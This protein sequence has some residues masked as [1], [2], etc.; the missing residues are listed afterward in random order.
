MNKAGRGIPFNF[1]LAY[2]SSVWVPGTAW[3]PSPTWGWSGLSAAGQ[4]EISYTMS[5]YNGR[6]EDDNQ[7]KYKYQQWTY[8]NVQY[9]DPKGVS[10]A[11]GGLFTYTNGSGPD[12]GSGLC[13][14]N[15]ANPVGPTILPSTDGSGLSASALA[16]QAAMRIS[17][18]DASGK[19]ISAPIV[20]N[21]QSQQ[22]TYSLVDL[23]GNEITLTNGQYTDTTGAVALSV[24]GAS[25]SNT[26]LAYTTTAG[27][28][29]NYT[30]S[31]KAYTVK[32]AF[33]C[34]YHT[35]YGPT[36][37]YLVD[38]VTLTDNSFYQFSYEA[39][40]GA[41]GDV[42][43]R[44]AS[45][46]LPTGGAVAYAYT[47]A[48]N[49]INCSDGSALGLTRTTVATG[50]SPASTWTYARTL[51]GSTTSHTEVVD[52]LVNHLAYDFMLAQSRIGNINFTNAMYYETARKVYQGAESGTPVISRT[53]CYDSLQPPCNTVIYTAITA[54][55][56]YEVLDGLQEHGTTT[57][58]GNSG[59]ITEVDLYDFGG[60][61]TRGPVL[62][63]QTWTYPT[64]G[65]TGLLSNTQ[66][67]DAAGDVLSSTSYVYDGGTLTP[68]TG[69]PQH[70][71]VTGQRGN[72]TSIQQ[73]SAGHTETTNL[74][75]ED[76]GQA[77]TSTDPAT[78]KTTLTYD[79]ATHVNLIG[80]SQKV[81]TLTLGSTYAYYGNTGLLQTSTD[82]NSQ[83]T[84]LTYDT[85]LRN[86]GV[87]YPDGG[88]GTATYSI[89][90]NNSSVTQTVLHASGTPITSVTTVD[91]YGRPQ[92]VTVT[93]SPA[94]DLV[95]AVYDANGNTYS[96]S[97]PYRTT[98]D[99]TYGVTTYTHDVLG[100]LTKT[101]APDTSPSTAT[102]LGNT[103]LYADAANHQREILVDGMGRISQ[104]LEPNGTSNTP[105]MATNYSYLQ[106][107]NSSTGTTQAII[108]QT[109]GSATQS[110]WRTRT[111]TSDALGR[112]VSSA[113]PESG[114]TTYTY[115][116]FGNAYCAGNLM[117]PC[118]RTD[119][120]SVV[121]HYT[122]D[123]LNRP[124]GMT[125]TGITPVTPAIAYSYD[126]TA[127]NGL[128]I[129]NG[130]GR[131]TGMTDASGTSAWSFD[132]LGRVAAARKTLNSVTK[133]ANFTYNLDGTVKTLQDFGGTTL[134][135]TY[136]PVGLQSG[137]SDQ[138]G[139]TYAASGA[140]NAAGQLTSLTHQLTSGSAILQRALGYNSLLEPST[141]KATSGG[142]NIQNLTLGYGTPGQ[143]NGNIAGIVNGMDTTHGRDQTYAYD[144]LNR[145]SQGGDTSHW[146]EQYGYDAWGNMLSK[147][148]VRGSGT[149]F[150]V[151]ANGNN[152]LSN[153][154][155]DAAGQVTLDQ[156]GNH[157]TYD[158]EGRIL[159]GGAGTYTYDGDGNRVVKTSGGTTTLYWPSSVSGVVDESNA[160]ATAFGRQIFVAGVRVWSEDTAGSGRFLFQDH[161]GS[162]RVTAVSTGAAKDDYDYRS[163]GDIVTNY[164]AAP[165]DNHYVFTG[166][167]NDS[168]DTGTD[169]AQF[170]SLSLTMARFNRPD[171]YMGSYDFSNPQSSNRYG[172]VLNNPLIMIDPLGLGTTCVTDSWLTT[173]TVYNFNDGTGDSYGLDD[174]ETTDTG[175]G[176]C[177]D[178]GFDNSTIVYNNVDALE[179]GAGAPNNY[180]Q[181]LPNCWA[182]GGKAVL[183]AVGDTLGPVTDVPGLIKAG[184]DEATNVGIRNAVYNAT[185]Y[186]LTAINTKGGVG[187]LSPW[188]SSTYRAIVADTATLADIATGASLLY[189][190]YN[191]V[192]Q[193]VNE[194]KNPTPCR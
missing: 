51:T 128:T 164:G 18:T 37:N 52:G 43:G 88:A 62:E 108:Q 136:T 104:V 182:V 173:Q 123:A 67:L 48:N 121:A 20:S 139:N 156:L 16:L 94:N 80:V 63:T 169:F 180:E 114:T 113:V 3:T 5:L 166:Y 59:L 162:T 1:D 82:P 92:R 89:A 84:T 97:N 23:N 38:K 127:Y 192:K 190:D 150:S 187:L 142:A 151:T 152:Q 135:Y 73:T 131:R 61:S 12:D 105:T 140:Y 50:N 137:V 78:N 7:Q 100:R 75:Y 193:I 174:V 70:L 186:S 31:Y 144:T 32:T 112:L 120:R 147:T 55:D 11:F 141:I 98:G 179:G 9:L 40:P 17:L 54:V 157:F 176:G 191:L 183:N 146:G 126:Q 175:D 57:K 30:V 22:G 53:T 95:D 8:S 76:T 134:T 122:Y 132:T 119:A 19:K 79:A 91:A 99:P 194:I 145:V 143:N 167:E 133:Q 77:L 130:L 115:S 13:P 172:Y 2:N 160:T 138:S 107:F 155:Y 68:T 124:T 35:D 33:G 66:T 74:T 65:N 56:T 28:S 87:T 25:P 72:L 170:R 14:V 44:V 69:V 158:A 189:F 49:G 60:S 81:G 161:L 118:T 64:T 184:V 168:A 85:S 15:G 71:A 47:G 39:T 109:G 45:V 6:C 46:A 83:S 181:S 4:S 27:G 148:A 159:T 101:V 36:M 26:V 111:F 165:T 116:G 110:L 41:A 21:P 188:K 86:N 125:Y 171:P 103:T 129:A 178:D 163:F 10:H 102:T 185:L 29:A 106:N 24:V 58:F 153:L 34:T 90:A 93:D 177:Y 117:V 154:T 42:T 149:Q 96:V